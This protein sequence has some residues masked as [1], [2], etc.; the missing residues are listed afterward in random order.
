MRFTVGFIFLFASAQLGAYEEADTYVLKTGA[1]GAARLDFQ[2]KFLHPKSAEHLARAGIRAGQVVLDIGC[3][4]GS[5]TKYLAQI[6]GDTGRVYA[7]DRS[8]EQLELARRAI[9]DAG[10]K[11]V[12]FIQQDA[13]KDT[14][15][16]SEP[17]D[18]VFCRLL[19]M[20]VVQPDTLIQ[21]MAKPLKDSGILVLEEPALTSTKAEGPSKALEL[22]M[23]Y[24]MAL[25]KRL[26]LDFDMGQHLK[27]LVE[28]HNF[29]DVAETQWQP[30]LQPETGRNFLILSFKE[31]GPKAVDLGIMSDTERDELGAL[32]ETFDEKLYLSTYH[33]VTARKGAAL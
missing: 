7:I 28:K 22:Y 19:L 26:G 24:V 10:Y 23:H 32:L 11:N 5:M 9:E 29:H 33:Y 1:S 15:K 18:L 31:W 6:V 4:N 21:H 12:I 17:A 27:T 2:N 13:L 8:Q 25:G 14:I 20:H 3:G 16:V 30:E